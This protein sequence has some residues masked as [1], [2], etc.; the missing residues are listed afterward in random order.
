MIRVEFYDV[1]R[2]RAGV[3]MVEVEARTVG[4]ALRAAAELRP[5]LVPDVIVEGRT[6][7]HWRVSVN[8]GPFL[9]DLD[10]EITDGDAVLLLSALAGG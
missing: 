6:G 7:P 1:A 4:A 2:V 8:G 9:V 10:T 5:G 3:E